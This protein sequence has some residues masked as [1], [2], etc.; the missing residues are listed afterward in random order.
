VLALLLLIGAGVCELAKRVRRKRSCI[1]Q[2]KD[3]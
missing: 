1:H 2:K 3:T